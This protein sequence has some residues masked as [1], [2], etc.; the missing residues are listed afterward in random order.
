[1]ADNLRDVE[2]RVSEMFAAYLDDDIEITTSLDL[3]ADVALASVQV[4]EVI[5]GIEDHY[6]VVIELDALAS[7]RTIEQLALIVESK[8][9]DG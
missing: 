6:D 3:L 8:L 2:K 5:V 4:M 9:A 7:V 1:M